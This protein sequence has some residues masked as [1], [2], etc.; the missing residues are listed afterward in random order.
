MRKAE[1]VLWERYQGQGDLDARS[2]L[3]EQHLGLVH[4]IARQIA[5]RVPDGVELD[6]LVSAGALGL[7][8]ALE[9]FEP[10]RRLAFST[11]ATPRI[12]GSILDDLRSRDW[13]PRSVRSKSRKIA[14]AVGHLEGTLGR[15]PEPNEIATA[16]GI[17]V[18]TFFRWQ[19]DAENS[20]LLPLD[21]PVGAQE[22]EA[23]T[24]AE[25]LGDASGIRADHAVTHKEVLEALRGAIGDL[26]DK[27]RTVL[28]LYYYE[29]LNLRQIAEVL[30]LTESRISQIRSQALNRLQSM[31]RP[32]EV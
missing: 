30:N 10:A 15:T 21:G 23:T 27:E 12:R 11:Y 28:A 1:A 16:I 8:L 24:L 19:E 31:L 25:T 5:E 17:D 18:T 2:Q 6:D 7:V 26:P 13:V 20:V 9:S 22:H 3:L 14:H 29:E 32:V 4:H